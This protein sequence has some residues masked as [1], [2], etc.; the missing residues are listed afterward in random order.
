MSASTRA[1]A[2]ALAVS[3]LL[4][5]AMAVI[6]TSVLRSATPDR[7]PAEAVK[8]ATRLRAQQ[9]QATADADR[10][11]YDVPFTKDMVRDV[12]PWT[13][14]G[15]PKTVDVTV[16]NATP[17]A[18]LKQTA[19]KCIDAYRGHAG[20]QSVQCYVFAS[21]EAY[22][23]L[24]QTKD[25]Q[26]NPNVKKG[27]FPVSAQCYAIYAKADGS[28]APHIGDM[29]QAKSMWDSRGCPASWSGE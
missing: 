23:A 25:L 28:A 3:T 20:A 13:F 27:T 11:V 10:K 12:V 24:N 21:E 16:V 26:S 29:R 4:V 19:T 7:S 6:C 17:N 22:T 5:I 1:S 15:S 9:A 2:I 14:A 8:H 18:D